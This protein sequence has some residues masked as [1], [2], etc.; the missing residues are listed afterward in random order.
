MYVRYKELQSEGKDASNY[1]F[2]PEWIIFWNKR[3]IELHNSE[4]KTK[5]DA[6]RRRCGSF[7]VFILLLYLVIKN[8]WLTIKVIFDS[9]TKS[10]FLVC[11]KVL[12]CF[13]IKMHWY[14]SLCTILLKYVKSSRIFKE[15]VPILVY[16]TYE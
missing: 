10:L 5:K 7:M 13:V 16:L 11:A 12:M 4:V 9:A 6:L 15:C 8:G 1:D 2:K 3:M 14:I